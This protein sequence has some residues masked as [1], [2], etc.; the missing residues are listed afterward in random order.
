MENP[1]HT[2]LAWKRKQQHRSPARTVDRPKKGCHQT[3]TRRQKEHRNS[4]VWRTLSTF[5]QA[6]QLTLSRESNRGG[7]GKRQSSPQIQIWRHIET[8]ATPLDQRNR[9]ST[10]PRRFSKDPWPAHQ[11]YTARWR[12][13]QNFEK[14]N[15]EKEGEERRR[16]WD[17]KERGR[18]VKP[19]E[20]HAADCPNR[21]VRVFSRERKRLEREDFLLF[22]I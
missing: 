10:P 20:K 3:P 17:T 16:R 13:G 2:K 14:G 19:E 12:L 21:G 5:S 9:T 22:D 7:R 11:I 8:T 4:T 18:P 6:N 15:G 1:Q